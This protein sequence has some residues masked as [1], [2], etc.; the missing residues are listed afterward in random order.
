MTSKTLKSSRLQ[1]KCAAGASMLLLAAAATTANA[2]LVDPGW[3]IPNPLVPFATVIG[4]GTGPMTFGQW[5]Q[6]SSTITGFVGF[7]NPSSPSL[8]LS[9]TNSGGTTTQTAQAINLSV[10][11]YAA[12]VAG[13]ATAT[14]GGFFNAASLGPV[15]GVSISFFSGLNYNSI[16]ANQT[17]S[18][19]S[20]LD[21]SALTWELRQIFQQP[22]PTNAM[23]MLVQVYYSDASLINS[24]GVAQAGYVD[25][26]FLRINPVPEPASWALMGLGAL[27]V[28]WRLRANTSRRA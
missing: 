9:M 3:D 13:G 2:Q 15:G 21:S 19:A 17:F 24:A 11:P 28:A 23:A 4:T 18:T 10:S 20:A 8:M 12:M 6:E 27:G 25:E 5:G 26:T 1:A 14:F 22:I 7:V 16:I